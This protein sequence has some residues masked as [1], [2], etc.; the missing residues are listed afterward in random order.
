M[1]ER[2]SGAL[3]VPSQRKTRR[4]LVLRIAA[5]LIAEPDIV[6]GAMRHVR[7]R[8][9]PQL[10]PVPLTSYPGT[11]DD[12]SFSPDGTQVAFT[13]CKDTAGKECNVYIKDIGVEPP[14]KLTG[15]PAPEY[16]SV[17]SPD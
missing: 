1:Q 3:K 7:A 9:E 17:W 14:F 15:Q 16:S 8:P 5:A 6:S 4:R 2:D 12:P 11:E 13:W 10:V